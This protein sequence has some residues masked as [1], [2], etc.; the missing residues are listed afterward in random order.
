LNQLI[1]DD[2]ALL[3]DRSES[4]L[5]SMSILKEKNE[6]T[7]RRMGKMIKAGCLFEG[8]NLHGILRRFFQLET[9]GILKIEWPERPADAAAGAGKSSRNNDGNVYMLDDGN[10]HVCFENYRLY[11]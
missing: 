9:E 7:H 8:T 10:N 11:T 2:N 5:A 6:Q 4:H 3:L 1:D